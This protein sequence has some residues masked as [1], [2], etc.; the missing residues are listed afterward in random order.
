VKKGQIVNARIERVEFPNKGIGRVI[1]ESNAENSANSQ[2]DESQDNKAQYVTVKNTVAGQLVSC[3]INKIRH[4]KAEGALL[5]VIERAPVEI[6]PPC[7]HFG[8]C[9]G[10]TYQNL[11]YEEQLK[12]KREQVETVMTSSVKCDHE[13]YEGILA[14]PLTEE[15]RNKMEFTFG[16][17]YKDGPLALGMHKRGSFYDIVTVDSCRLVHPDYR[18]ILKFTRDYFAQRDIPYFHR[19]RHEG[20]LRHLLVRR[21]VKTEEILIDIVTTTQMDI[22]LTEWVNGLHNL[23]VSGVLKGKIAGILHTSNDSIA[24]VVRN[25]GT[26]VLYG[27]D[28]FYEELLGLKFRI[29]P[30]SFFQ[31]NS[32]G[33]QVLYEKTREYALA[34]VN[35]DGSDSL[36]ERKPVI[37]DLYS[38]TGTI[39]Q[40]MAP[41]ADHVIGVEIIEEAVGAAKENAEQNGLHNC[42]FV[43]GDVLKVI[44]GLSAPEDKPDLIILDPP[45]DGCHPKA[46]P[47]IIA[48]GAPS[49]VYVSCKVTSLARDLILLQEGG[50][51]V[52]KACAID[53]FPGTGHVESVCLLSK[54]P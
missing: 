7:P 54:K 34:A 14:S 15:Y 20:Y 51:E 27:E 46:L 39:A 33:A 49:I 45:R 19:V 52:V 11:P 2:S 12:L 32:L 47:K 43:A 1:S 50:Y 48:Y 21:G 35:V 29:T 23:E 10:C 36:L 24:D 22:D 3:R 18:A 37:F 40:M 5:E 17:E 41:V 31:T 30:F 42:E 26:E 16:D 38:G 13:W 28:Y 9:G 53:Q 4:K 6:D 44:D 8:Q 25:D